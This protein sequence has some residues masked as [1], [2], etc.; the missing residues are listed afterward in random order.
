MSASQ[1]TTALI[2]RP[3]SLKKTKEKKSIHLHNDDGQFHLHEAISLQNI[4][5]E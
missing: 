5:C 4:K 1:T 2:T 3:C